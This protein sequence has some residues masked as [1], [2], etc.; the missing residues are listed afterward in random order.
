MQDRTTDPGARSRLRA[1]GQAIRR[2]RGDLTQE[3]LG[4]LLGVPQ[5]TV[6]RWELGYVDLG[7]EQVRH[8]EETLRLRPG[9]LLAEG[10]YAGFPEAGGA[11]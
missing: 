8:I 11:Q 10:G 7:V 2:A 5:T 3:Q 9:D 6:S 4:D 1:L